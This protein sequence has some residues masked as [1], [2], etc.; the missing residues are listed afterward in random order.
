[1]ATAIKNGSEVK[2]VVAKPETAKP[3]KLTITPPKIE[4]CEVK[5][6][7]TSPYV[8]NRFAAKAMEQ[9]KAKQASG[10]QAN[11]GKKRDAKDFQECY[12]QAQHVSPDG[13][14]GIPAP[15]FRNGMIEACRLVG[16][17]RKSTRLNSSH[18]QISYAV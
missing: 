16:L 2:T 8:Q 10:S 15:A 1:M 3:E 6:V 18:S 4:V 17:D 13:W 14:H 5:I 12:R 7:G 9:M 11:K